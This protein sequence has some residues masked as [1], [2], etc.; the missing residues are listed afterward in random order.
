MGDPAYSFPRSAGGEGVLALG[1][2]DA[3]F[4]GSMR[5]HLDRAGPYLQL[6]I[7][8]LIVG[9]IEDGRL[10]SG[11]RMPSSREMAA[12][13]KVSR[14]TVVLAYEQLVEQGFL[15]SRARS[16]YFVAERPAGAQIGA[17]EEH[18]RSGP[19]RWADRYAVRP[20]VFRNIVKPLDWQAYPYPFISGQFDPD[21]FPTNDWRESA[22]AALSVTE[23]NNWA[24]D[25]ID[26]DDPALIDQLRRHVL[27]ARGVRAR[28]D[29]I[30][31]TIGAQHAL[32]LVAR[33]FVSP[34]TRVGVEN[35][36]YPDTRNIVGM[37][38]KDLVPL[39]VDDEGL[40]PDEAFAQCDIVFAT[41]GHQCPTTGVQ[42]LERRLALLDKARERDIV[43]VEDDYDGGLIQT[44]ETPPPLKSLDRD[45]RVFYVGGLSKTLA[46]GLRLGYVVAPAPTIR[47]LRALRRLN[48]RHAPLNNQ[49]VAAAFIGLGHYRAHMARISRVLGERAALLDRLLPGALGDCAVRRSAGGVSYWVVGP[50]GCDS[51]ALSAEARQAGVLIEPGGV[52]SM[53]EATSRHCFRLGFSSIRTDRIEAGVA[54]LAEAVA[55][56]S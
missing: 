33:L 27:P 56:M 4:W 36:G 41:P 30:M 3:R 14:N 7:R 11:A 34:E 28:P 23:I 13:L 29:E 50:Q 45:E 12:Y 16:G 9:A 15:Q 38:T 18:V 22:R 20:S 35:P 48:L 40:V 54:R 53:D 39:A 43:L 42:S 6:Q 1:I 47:E 21:L 52:F 10:P 25:M 2:D 55:R 31:V 24:R 8:Q 37:L 46:P 49:R 32:Y 5:E 51:A 44:A 19:D 26:E 17:A